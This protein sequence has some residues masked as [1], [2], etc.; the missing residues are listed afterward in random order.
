MEIHENS[1]PGVQPDRHDHSVEIAASALFDALLENDAIGL[2]VLDRRHRFVRVNR[3]FAQIDDQPLAAHAGRSV[4]EV[5]PAIAAALDFAIE[6]VFATGRAAADVE[7]QV[8]A[9]GSPDAL[10]DW[11]AGCFPILEAGRPAWVGVILQDITA[12][13]QREARLALLAAAGGLLTAL[14]DVE[15]ALQSVANLVVPGFAD[16]CAVE[17][18]ADQG[19]TQQIAVAHV[20]PQKVA[21]AEQLRR[22]FRPE[23][24]STTGAPNVIR[25]GQS[26]FYP[27]ITDD[28]LRAG[29]TSAEQLQVMREV[30]LHSAVIVPLKAR[31]RIVGALTLVY[32]ESQR[33]YTEAD[34]RL[35]EELANYAALAIDNA[36]LYDE[37][38]RAEAEVRLLNDTLEQHVANR[39]ADLDRSNRD[40]Q[41][42]AYIASHD[43][44]EPLRKIVAFSDRL[45]RL[46]GP[47]LDPTAGDYLA[48]MQN[49]AGRM[50][51][52]INDLLT[53]SRI[54]TRGLQ[55]TPVDLAK[56][57]HDEV[58][59]DLETALE[60][61]G[62][63]IEV[64]ELPHLIADPLQMRQLMQNLIGNGLKFRR[65]GV[66]PLVRVAGE[67]IRDDAT[68]ALVYRIVVQD[69]G[70]GFDNKYLDRI[71]QPFQRLHG[72]QQYAGTG[73][74]LAICRKISE[75]HGGS[76]TARGEI[77][78]GA[79]F[80]VTLP[81]LLP[82]ADQPPLGDPAAAPA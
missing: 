50:Q 8:A 36:R 11:L 79:T 15:L 18:I 23:A 22:R 28:M 48:R 42:F 25:T 33:T 20:D 2:A 34:V 81:A 73:M 66:A 40:L 19:D 41:D 17:V 49:A 29:A 39:T 35:A 77:D 76:I 69:N 59:V 10:R 51:G 82:A 55:L 6:E 43:L 47:N 72:R 13:K 61:S 1:S 38:R 27:R 21:W 30:G 62:G 74:G 56:V 46:L 80:V 58:L 31:G 16:W 24:G 53:L 78:Q 37:A 45:Y 9:P 7:V 70:I 5:A 71:F 64:G 44:Q 54:S 4:S 68:D 14:L 32:A 75:R 63:Q 67:E 57:I 12:R 65:P 52:L 3:R 60:E 26:E